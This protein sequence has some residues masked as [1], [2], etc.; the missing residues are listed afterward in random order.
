MILND[1]TLTLATM[2]EGG[3]MQQ[4]ARPLGRGFDGTCWLL[5]T[6]SPPSI[7]GGSVRQPQKGQSTCLVTMLSTTP[8]RSLSNMSFLSAVFLICREHSVAML[9][10]PT[11]YGDC[12]SGVKKLAETMA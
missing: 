9:G 8:S 7:S 3:N 10:V 1:Y 6:T 4:H 5:C 12:L 2:S 11:Q